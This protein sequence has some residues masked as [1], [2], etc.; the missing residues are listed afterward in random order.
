M[1]LQSPCKWKR[2]QSYDNK[3]THK[4]IDISLFRNYCSNMKVSLC[5]CWVIMGLWM[6]FYFCSL[7]FQFLTAPTISYCVTWLLY[8][9]HDWICGWNF[10]SSLE[11]F[12]CPWCQS[13]SICETPPVTCSP[14]VMEL[15]VARVPSWHVKQCLRMQV[16]EAVRSWLVTM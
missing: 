6:L 11:Y 12:Q 14:R 9:W 5:L 8:T 3:V 13:V 15:V 7:P 4:L 2:N 1:N 16:Q 10:S